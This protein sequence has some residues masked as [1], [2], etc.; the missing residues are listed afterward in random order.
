MGKTKAETRG[1]S[2][3]DAAVT[4]SATATGFTTDAGAAIGGTAA[5]MG[6]DVLGSAWLAVTMGSAG[7][8]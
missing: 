2:R 6:L 3:D 7:V 5:G 4:A 8:A 1:S